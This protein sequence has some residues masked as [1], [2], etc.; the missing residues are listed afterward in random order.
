MKLV[1]GMTLH[2]TVHAYLHTNVYSYIHTYIHAYIYSDL[3]K[4]LI[5]VLQRTNDTPRELSMISPR[6]IMDPLYDDII[7]GSSIAGR[8]GW[9]DS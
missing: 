8:Y 4:Q 7:E 3:M 6:T 9:I 1:S 2:Y 5:Y